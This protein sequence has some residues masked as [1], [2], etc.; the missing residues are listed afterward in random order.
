MALAE[1]LLD[2]GFWGKNPKVRSSPP[3]PSSDTEGSLT[4]INREKG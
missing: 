1:I 3:V 2:L 4:L